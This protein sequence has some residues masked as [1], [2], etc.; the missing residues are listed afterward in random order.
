MKMISKALTGAAFLALAACGGK[1]DDAAADNASD[2]YE[3]QAAVVQD[4]A[5]NTT[6]EVRQD[7]LEDRADALEEKADDVADKIDDSDINA[8]AVNA[9]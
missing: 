3:N 2:M 9:Q 7:Q 8:E 6:N 1:G 4:M 5:D